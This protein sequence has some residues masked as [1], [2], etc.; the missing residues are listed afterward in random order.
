MSNAGV[1]GMVRGLRWASRDRGGREGDREI[2]GKRGENGR[3][4]GREGKKG[5]VGEEGKG[6]GGGGGAGIA[7][8]L[9]GVGVDGPGC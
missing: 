7:S 2:M 9:Q 6:E 3:E 1:D 4:S 8:S 5:G